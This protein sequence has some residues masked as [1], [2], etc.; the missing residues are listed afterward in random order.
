MSGIHAFMTQQMK[1]D[2]RACGFSE[3]QLAELSPQEGDEILAAAN[4]VVP[5]S[6]EVRKIH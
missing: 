6:H 2:L 1:A 4:I 3:Q 5:D